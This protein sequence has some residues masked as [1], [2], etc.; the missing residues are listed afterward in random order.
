[1]KKHLLISLIS[2]LSYASYAQINYEK[3]Y[4]IDNEGNRT[5]CLIKNIDWK[6]NP[7]EFKYKLSEDSESK[8]S[9]IKTIKEFE[10]SEVKYIRAT[11]E[12]DHS[13]DTPLSS[14]STV[15]NPTFNTEQLFLKILAEGK[16][17]LYYFENGN[18]RRFFYKTENP[19]IEQFV[20]KR[21]KINNSKIGIN[22]RY[23]QQL[24]TILNCK[25]LSKK[26]IKNIGYN[27]KDLIH[28][29]LKNNNCGNYKPL[30]SQKKQEKLLH[31]SLNIGIQNS[32]LYIYNDR[33]S[34]R[35]TDFG[36]NLGLRIGLEVEFT[37]PFNKNKWALLINP[38]YQSFKGE[39]KLNTSDVSVTYSS[40]ELPVGIRHSFF[41]N[42]KSKIFVNALYVLD[43]PLESDIIFE[44][45]RDLQIYKSTNVAFG[46]GYSFNHKFSLEFRYGL[47]R[48]ALSRYL[49]WEANYTHSSLIIGYTLF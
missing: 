36:N 44:P 30:I 4:F 47:N 16:I 21:Y 41:L 8:T 6:N 28:L 46:I 23:K 26:E 10:V 3:G 5:E 45:G 49:Y 40:I 1:M 2:L 7:T 27:K 11:V 42:N 39:K 12:I 24:I 29:I 20:Y 34:F 22:N 19:T 32:S 9:T 37:L 15:R 14:L 33:L 18:L 31:T 13:N 48:D 35:N 25:S 38:T 43:F 17:N